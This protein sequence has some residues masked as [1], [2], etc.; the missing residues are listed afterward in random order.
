[1]ANKKWE[2]FLQQQHFCF[3]FSNLLHRSLLTF[4]TWLSCYITFFQKT[5]M[6]SCKIKYMAVLYKQYQLRP[7]VNFCYLLSLW[8]T[9]C[10]YEDVRFPGS[11]RTSSPLFSWIIHSYH[12]RFS[13]IKSF[14]HAFNKYFPCELSAWER[15]QA[16]YMLP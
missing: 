14:Q 3:V 16:V 10:H 4:K 8:H 2:N 12:H 5:E 6:L 9:A 15:E 13:C 1:M 11:D 7:I